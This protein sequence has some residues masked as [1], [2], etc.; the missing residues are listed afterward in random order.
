M[1]DLS[2]LKDN[3][4]LISPCKKESLSCLNKSDLS[5]KILSKNDLINNLSFDYDDKAIIY[6]M[7]KGYSYSNAKELIS[8]LHFIKDGNE[9]L[10][11][12]YSL[13][14]ELLDNN[15]IKNNSLFSYLLKDKQIYIYGYSSLD[16]I[17][18]CSLSYKSANLVFFKICN[19]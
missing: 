4:M 16:K 13:K 5:I 18:K 3:S 15:L 9:K 17:L 1:I 10:N 2:V 14:Q 7:K 8:C 11:K 19:I 6:L 12:L